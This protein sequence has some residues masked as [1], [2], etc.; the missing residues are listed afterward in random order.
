MIEFQSFLGL[1]EYSR[2]FVKGFSLIEALLAK[3]LS[4][5]APFV[6]AI[7]QKSTFAELKLVLTQ[8]SILIQPDS[9][10]EFVFYSDALLIGLGCLLMQ[11]RKVVAYAFKQLKQ[12]EG[13]Y[14]S[15]S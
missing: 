14:L 11:E 13:N 7:K 15:D 9:R 2:R 8:V 1:A 3:L 10:K 4:K 6:W 12:H 5:N